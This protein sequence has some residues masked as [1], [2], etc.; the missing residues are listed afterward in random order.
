MRIAVG[1]FQHETNTFAPMKAS[2]A[3]FRDGGAWPRLQ[4]GAEMLDNMV[5]MNLPVAGA[6]AALQ[7][8]GRELVPLV[9]AATVPSAHVTDDAYERIA[10]MMLDDLRAAGLDAHVSLKLTAMGLDLDEALPLELVAAVAERPEVAAGAVRAIVNTQRALRADP[11]L[12]TKAARRLFPP[13][14]TE[15]IAELIR[16]DLPYYDPSIS[17]QTFEQLN[18]FAEVTQPLA[19]EQVVFKHAQA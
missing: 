1:G 11:S 2:F 8:T 9:W 19:Y 5:G 10:G 3:D 14:E 16:R 4:R 18:Q 12:A 7:G 17:R 15:L 6:I 13:E